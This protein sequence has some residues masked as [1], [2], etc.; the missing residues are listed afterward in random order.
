[1]EKLVAELT[2][3][4]LLEVMET[5]FVKKKKQ[6]PLI[7]NWAVF[8]LV[9]KHFENRLTPE[10]GEMLTFTQIMKEM[11]IINPNVKL[12]GMAIRDILK[13]RRQIKGIGYVYVIRPKI[14]A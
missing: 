9:K 8:E 14:V 4:E 12:Y 6:T 7:K 3:K 1:M 11:G 10:T 13:E 5:I 2:V